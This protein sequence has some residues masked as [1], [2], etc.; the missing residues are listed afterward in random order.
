MDIRYTY[1]VSYTFSGALTSV[2]G[3]GDTTVSMSREIDSYEQ[4]NEIRSAIREARGCQSV[5][6]LNF[7]LLRKGVAS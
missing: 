4:L 5:V 6:I 7:V 1:F 2:P 3:Y